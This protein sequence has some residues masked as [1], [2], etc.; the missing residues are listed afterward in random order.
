MICEAGEKAQKAHNVL[1]SQ[2]K[3]F[4]EKERNGQFE[5]GLGCQVWRGVR[6]L[7]IPVRE[8]VI[9]IH[10]FTLWK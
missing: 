10:A 5:M 2:E 1:E 6:L 8:T 9:S 3:R 4:K 7:S